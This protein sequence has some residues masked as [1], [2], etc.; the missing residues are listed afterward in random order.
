MSKLTHCSKE[1]G[2]VLNLWL[3]TSKQHDEAND[4]H[5]N[6]GDVAEASP[7]GPICR[8]TNKDGG[9]RRTRIRRHREELRPRADVAHA[10]QDGGEEEGE[11]IQRHQAAHVDDHVPIRLPILGGSPDISLVKVFSGSTLTVHDETA[12][13]ADAILGGQETGSIRP[14]KD[15]PPAKDA[16]KDG[17]QTL[18]DEDPSPT[19]FAAD[20]V[21][22]S[23]GSS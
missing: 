22:L 2:A 15:H 8:E 14:V 7:F 10:A 3:V 9:Q 16:N 4:T 5:A 18:E 21:H 6:S 1:D 11:G 12:L 13:N 17:R 20:A 19:R 23:N